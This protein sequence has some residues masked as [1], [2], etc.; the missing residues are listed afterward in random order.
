MYKYFVI[1]SLNRWYALVIVRGGWSTVGT[2][3]PKIHDYLNISFIITVVPR[4]RTSDGGRVLVNGR[5]VN[6]CSRTFD[7]RSGAL[8]ARPAHEHDEQL[9]HYECDEQQG[10]GVGVP[11]DGVL[12]LVGVRV[13]VDLP[14]VFALLGFKFEFVLD[15]NF[16]E[17]HFFGLVPDTPSA[18]PSVE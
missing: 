9:E 13:E 2:F 11:V 4:N 16:L 8:D 7:S 5:I 18:T 3:Y 15:S 1:L 14:A 10:Q 6:G 12:V 17:Y